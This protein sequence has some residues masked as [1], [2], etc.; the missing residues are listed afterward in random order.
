MDF[1]VYFE[2]RARTKLKPQEVVEGIMDTQIRKTLT[3]I[4]VNQK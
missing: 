2:D 3:T 4:A 1:Y